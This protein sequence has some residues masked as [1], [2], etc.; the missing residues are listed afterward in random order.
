MVKH[1]PRCNRDL[2]ID[3]FYK[4]RK[5]KDGH[6]NWC[7]KCDTDYRRTHEGLSIENKMNNSKKRLEQ[8]VVNKLSDTDAAYIAGFLDGEGSIS[9]NKSHKNDGRTPS[10]SLSVK[11]TQNDR[12]VLDWIKVTVGMGTICTHSYRSNQWT[13]RSYRVIDFLKQIYPYLKVKRIQADVAFKYLDTVVFASEGKN[14]LPKKVVDKRE[15]LRN[16][17]LAANRLFKNYQEQ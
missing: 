15:V 1:C 2:F 4:D 7:K 11:I 5:C 12:N 3:D 14:K 9:L 17:M 6:Q 16:E 8:K 13:F 10:Y